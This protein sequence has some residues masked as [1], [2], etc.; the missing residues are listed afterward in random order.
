MMSKNCHNC[1]LLQRKYISKYGFLYRCLYT[2]ALTTKE[3]QK[4]CPEKG[5]PWYRINDK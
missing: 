3:L 4:D 1:W 2:T 5:L